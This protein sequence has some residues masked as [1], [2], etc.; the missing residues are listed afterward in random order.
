MGFKL[1][2]FVFMMCKIRCLFFAIYNFNDSCI[3]N[4]FLPSSI[5]LRSLMHCKNSDYLALFIGFWKSSKRLILFFQFF[6]SESCSLYYHV[7]SNFLI[8]PS[9]NSSFFHELRY[10][11]LLK[12]VWWDLVYIFVFVDAFDFSDR[13]HY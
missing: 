12:H 3:L 7:I 10:F 6:Y 8:N 1:L 13:I 2:Q 4:F 9:S 11:N 5:I